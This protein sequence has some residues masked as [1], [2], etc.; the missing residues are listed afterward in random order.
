MTIRHALLPCNGRE[1]DA[2]RGAVTVW[3]ALI[4]IAV[5]ASIL[6]VVDGGARMR[7]ATQADTYAAEAARAA[8]IAVTPRSAGASA[9]ARAATRAAQAYLAAAGVSGT[10]KIIGP[11]VVR[12]TVAVSGRGPISGASFT[13]SRTATALLQVGVEGGQR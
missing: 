5:L 4:A 11:A 10:V 7:A 9:D 3:V 6:L 8:T 1:D 13:M 12:V 2:Q